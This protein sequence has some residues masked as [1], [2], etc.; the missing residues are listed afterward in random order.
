MGTSCRRDLLKVYL[1]ALNY[2]AKIPSR[3]ARY[4]IT[5]PRLPFNR[6]LTATPGVS[7]RPLPRQVTPMLYRPKELPFLT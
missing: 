2:C 5:Q 7:W 3:F 4:R 6:N 1:S